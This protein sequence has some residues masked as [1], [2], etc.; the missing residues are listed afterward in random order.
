[1]E[2]RRRM[3]TKMG[4][5]NTEV[6][7]VDNE[8]VAASMEMANA[9]VQEATKRKKACRV[10]GD[11]S[12]GYEGWLW[13]PANKAWCTTFSARKVCGHKLF[14]PKEYDSAEAALQAAVEWRKSRLEELGKPPANIEF[15]P[16]QKSRA[17]MKE[18]KLEEGTWVE[19]EEEGGV[20]EEFKGKGGSGRIGVYSGAAFWLAKIHIPGGKQ[21]SK[22]FF[23][24]KYN[25]SKEEAFAAAVACREKWEKE[26]TDLKTLG[27]KDAEDRPSK[28][29][30]KPAAKRKALPLI[31]NPFFE[32]R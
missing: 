16:T 15:C 28:M 4:G 8:K 31:K 32:K 14:K 9:A 3:L 27:K 7:F 17:I 6:E 26:K 19:G 25:N 12:S 20:E 21:K 30:A 1:M 22:R 29:K 23:H 5:T 2:H 24:C 13:K 18:L 10:R 11:S